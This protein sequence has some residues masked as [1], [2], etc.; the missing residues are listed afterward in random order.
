MLHFERTFKCRGL[1]SLQ[2]DEK[3]EPL[4]QDR[5]APL[6]VP[7]ASAPKAAGAGEEAK[8]PPAERGTP[9]APRLPAKILPTKIQGE[10][11]V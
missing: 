2:G 4:R 11:I 3:S 6:A 10:H 9:S 1:A 7:P 5:A 8:D